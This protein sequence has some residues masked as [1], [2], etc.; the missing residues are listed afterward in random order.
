VKLKYN[1][2]AGGRYFKAGEEVPS[3]QVSLF[4]AE[5]AAQ[6]RQDAATNAE[7]EAPAISTLPADSE[8]I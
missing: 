1:L 3:D 7:P 5:L 6:E 2:I 4:A 8:R